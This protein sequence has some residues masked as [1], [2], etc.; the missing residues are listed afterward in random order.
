M[1]QVYSPERLHKE[2]RQA[3]V[4]MILRHR[5]KGCDRG[6]QGAQCECRATGLQGARGW[7]LRRKVNLKD[8][9]QGKTNRAGLAKVKAQAGTLEY[10]VAWKK[11]KWVVG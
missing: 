11:T 2:V 1:S 6:K 10:G 9:V 7:K 4:G 5:G 8:R 3:G